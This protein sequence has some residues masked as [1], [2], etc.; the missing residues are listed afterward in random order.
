MLQVC[1]SVLSQT[2]LA[3]KHALCDAGSADPFTA[4]TFGVTASSPCVTSCGGAISSVI[5]IWPF[6]AKFVDAR[7]GVAIAHRKGLSLTGLS[8]P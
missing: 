5:Y 6:A 8:W 7:A 4:I 2:V 3:Q 1:R